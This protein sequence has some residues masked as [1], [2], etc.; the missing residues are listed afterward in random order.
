MDISSVRIGY[1]SLLCIVSTS[2]W[3]WVFFFQ[4]KARD[5]RAAQRINKVQLSNDLL[6]CRQ[7]LQTPAPGPFEPI[8]METEGGFKDPL[9]SKESEQEQEWKLRQVSKILMYQY[10]EHYPPIT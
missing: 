8:S 10:L 3:P 5:N 7:L 4:Q 6:K 1:G 2:T 9:K